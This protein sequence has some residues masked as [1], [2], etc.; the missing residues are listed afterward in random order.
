MNIASQQQQHQQHPA[1]SR[2]STARAFDI[3]SQSSSYVSASQFTPPASY[4]SQTTPASSYSSTATFASTLSQNMPAPVSSPTTMT[5]TAAPT[6][7]QSSNAFFSSAHAQSAPPTHELDQQNVDTVMQDD[8]VA[9]EPSHQPERS[10][11][12]AP[13]QR[14]SAGQPTATAPFLRDFNLVAEAAKRAQ[15][16]VL[17]RDMEG[18]VL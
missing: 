1:Q 12:P 9:A 16:A 15:M 14:A 6:T 7:N 18:V 11:H 3:S 10:N 4:Q 2:S 17:M 8:D 13:P 5:T